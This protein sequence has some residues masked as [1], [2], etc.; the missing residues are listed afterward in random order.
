LCAQWPR[1][2]PWKKPADCATKRRRFSQAV[3]KR[4]EQGLASP[5]RREKARKGGRVLRAWVV[6]VPDRFSASPAHGVQPLW[7][8]QMPPV[9]LS[10]CHPLAPEPLT[11]GVPGV[12]TSATVLKLLNGLAGISST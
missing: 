6:Q 3:R 11:G 1:P 12:G 8:G 5:A 7:L 9:V 4:P 2:G 10:Y